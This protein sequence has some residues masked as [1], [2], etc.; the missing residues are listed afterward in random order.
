MGEYSSGDA[1]QKNCTSQAAEL[2]ESISP[3]REQASH[4]RRLSSPAAVLPPP[5]AH[6]ERLASTAHPLLAAR[7]L[8][9]LLLS[10]P[11]EPQ[12]EH[13]PARQFESCATNRG[14]RWGS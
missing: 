10:G 14:F 7:S 9:S 2:G 4:C 3:D 5:L 13:H 12:S 11:E 8:F 6:Y 1:R